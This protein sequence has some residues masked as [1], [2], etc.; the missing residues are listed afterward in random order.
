MASIF[1]E[2]FLEAFLVTAISAHFY[3]F[4]S[5]GVGES[6]EKTYYVNTEP[7]VCEFIKNNLNQWSL[8]FF[9]HFQ[10]RIG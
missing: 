9:L 3:D 8:K 7:T 4:G 6:F 2:V 10:I 5:Y 1:L